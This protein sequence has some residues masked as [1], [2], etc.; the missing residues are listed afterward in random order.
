MTS[1]YLVDTN[2][3]S[4]QAR[5]RPVQRVVDWLARQDGI[6]ISVITIEELTFGIARMTGPKRAKLERW[7]EELV[8]SGVEI[9]DVTPAIARASGAA[10]AGREAAGRQVAPEDMLIAATALVHG[11]TVATRNVRDFDG[12][13]VKVLDPFAT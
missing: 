3:L 8:S 11:L 4:E 6:A 2:V 9:F 13:G 1:L 10:R 7:L 12:C 5:P